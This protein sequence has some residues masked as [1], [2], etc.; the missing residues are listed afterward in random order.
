[1]YSANHQT[2]TWRFFLRAG[3]LIAIILSFPLAYWTAYFWDAVPLPLVDRL[4]WINCLFIG[5]FNLYLFGVFGLYRWQ[6]FIEIRLMLRL[7]A[8]SIF[9]GTVVFIVLRSFLFPTEVLSISFGYLPD[10]LVN[11]CFIFL[12]VATLR[13]SVFLFETQYLKSTRIECLAFVSWS[14]RMEPVLKGLIHNALSQASVTG[15]FSN[16]EHSALTPPPSLGFKELGALTDLRRLLQSNKITMLVLDLSDIG[17]MQLL[18]ISEICSDLMVGIVLIPWTFDVWSRRL[19]MRK[20]N[21]V[22]TMVIP[23][24]ALESFSNR[25]L[26]RSVDIFGAILGIIL[27][28]P[29]IIVL[30]YL[31]K[32]ESPGP[33]FYTQTRSGYRGKNFQIIKLRSMRL[34]ANDGTGVTRAVENDPRRLK[35]GEFIRKWNLDEVPQFWNVLKGEMSLVGPRPEIYELIEELRETL[36]C[37]NLRHLCKPGLTGWAAV[38][39]FRGNTSLEERIKYDQYYI[40]NWSLTFDLKIILMTLRPPKNAY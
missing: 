39:G 24:L 7:L 38:N 15:F 6:S 16:P 34:D 13:I 18:M 35:I 36:H 19:V 11:T 33:I 26:K 20:L 1:M 37:Y 4:T 32:R 31:I 8:L 14:D 3:D 30:G 21:G 23:E 40:E 9:T 28:A 12:L 2:S 25:I 10:L 27:S 29:L 5:F 22:P 17:E